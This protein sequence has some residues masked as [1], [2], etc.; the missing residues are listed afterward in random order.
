MKET[1]R[2]A[3]RGAREGRG[4]QRRGGPAQPAVREGARRPFTGRTRLPRG[5]PRG[6]GT[7]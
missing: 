6:S 3:A 5:S 7:L 2:G 4:R 1:G